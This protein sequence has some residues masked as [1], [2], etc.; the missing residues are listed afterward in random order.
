[1]R[2]TSGPGDLC[3][4][5]SPYLAPSDG[6]TFLCLVSHRIPP[7]LSCPHL[8]TETLLGLSKRLSPLQAVVF[9]GC[10]GGC[11]LCRLSQRL[12]SLQ[13]VSE[14]VVLAGCL[15]GCHLCRLPQRLL[16]LQA[17]LPTPHFPPMCSAR[18]HLI[19][20]SLP[21]ASVPALS[22]VPVDASR[23]FPQL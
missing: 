10:L 5:N 20:C 7:A 4:D 1:M 6:Y 8:T 21:G 14:A 16:S 18:V 19:L 9:V 11:N 3:W 15:R 2:L 12:P 23:W 17:P 13:A 22:W